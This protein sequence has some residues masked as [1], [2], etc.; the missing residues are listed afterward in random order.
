MLR[1]LAK[2]L[3]PPIIDIKRKQ[4]FTLSIDV[5]FKGEWGTYM[6]E[7]LNEAD[8][9]IFNK[10][11]IQDLIKRQRQ[12]FQNANRLFALVMFELWRREYSISLPS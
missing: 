4:G 1:K 10:N 7:V 2:R 8:K 12:G 3:L 11:I 6:S 5:W 9:D